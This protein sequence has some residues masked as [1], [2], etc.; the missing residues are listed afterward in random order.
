MKNISQKNYYLITIV[1]IAIIV[2]AS[3]VVVRALNRTTADELSGSTPHLPET[4]TI[5]LN[6]NATNP[7]E[8][9]D[10]FAREDSQ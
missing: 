8:Q 6:S 2:L 5:D 9:I 7:P 1:A 10:I 4:V 3:L